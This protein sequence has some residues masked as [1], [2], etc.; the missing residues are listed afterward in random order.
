[1]EKKTLLLSNGY[2]FLSFINERRAFK[3][4]FKNKIEIISTWDHKVKWIDDAYINHPSTV[5]L[6]EPIKRQTFNFYEKLISF[7]KFSLMKRDNSQCQYCGKKL[8]VSEITI[9][10]VMPKSRGGKNSFLNCVISCMP[11]N[12]RKDSKTL[13]ESGLKLIKKPCAPSFTKKDFI[14]DDNI[15]WHPEWN[16]FIG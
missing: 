3:L 8:K 14:L 13:E 7:N 2:E 16:N 9:D 12:N 11:C 5:R 1:M 4:L 6:I 15:H 10:H